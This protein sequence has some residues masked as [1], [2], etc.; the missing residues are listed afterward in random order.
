MAMLGS[1]TSISA[2]RLAYFLNLKGPV[3]A[4]NTA[5]SSSLVA[6][7][8]AYQA[9][10]NKTVDVALAGGITIW[11]H[12]AAFVSMQDAGMLSPTGVCRPFDKD[13]DGTMVGDGVGMLVLKRRAE[14]QRD[15][16]HIYGVIRGSGTNQDGRTAGITVPSFL[17]QS[18]LQRLS[19]ANKASMSVTFNISRRT[20]QQPNWAIRL[21]FMP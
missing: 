13:A 9:L 21:K 6:I 15:G 17:A 3:L 20:A 14:A 7:D 5:C 2:S 12:P 19:I 11:T 16:D 18:R 8:L 1:D 4:I 10:R